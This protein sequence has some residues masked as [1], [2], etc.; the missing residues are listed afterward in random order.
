MH[1]FEEEK[2]VKWSPHQT[3]KNIRMDKLLTVDGSV[4][5]L[6]ISYSLP[7]KESRNDWMRFL[8]N[9]HFH[10][11]CVFDS[12]MRWS[13][14][15]FHIHS[16]PLGH[17]EI[18][19]TVRRFFLFFHIQM[20]T[21][22][23]ERVLSQFSKQK[24]THEKKYRNNTTRSQCQRRKSSADYKLPII[25]HVHL[26][27]IL[28]LEKPKWT[29]DVGNRAGNYIYTSTKTFEDSIYIIFCKTVA[30]DL[31]CNQPFLLILLLW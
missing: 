24:R 7:A 18:R 15:H 12:M 13:L 30:R 28:Q 22:W 21:V 4:V 16:Y 31:L 29:S 3:T 8:L 6:F 20:D 2:G 25:N 19:Y 14:D 1:V 10:F 5:F 17:T 26:S 11:V 23:N 9:A 27:K